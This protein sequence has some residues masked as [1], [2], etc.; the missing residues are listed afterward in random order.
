MVAATPLQLP[1]PSPLQI[2]HLTTVALSEV[3]RFITL[4]LSLYI[5]FSFS[6]V[7]CSFI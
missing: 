5:D 3:C 6:V 4:S 7:L 2:S 1:D